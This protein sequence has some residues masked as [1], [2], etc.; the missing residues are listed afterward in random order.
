MTT[1]QALLGQLYWRE[2]LWLLLVLFPLAL[3]LWKRFMQQTSLRQYADSALHPW[4]KANRAAKQ[5]YWLMVSPFVIWLLLGISA[6]GPRLLTVTPDEVQPAQATAIIIVDQSR[7]MQ[8]SDVHPSRL[9]LAHNTLSQWA[10]DSYQTKTG[11]IIFAGTSHVVLPPTSDVLA[12][13]R[14]TRVIRE[15]QLPVHGSA[16]T[17]AMKQA[18][19]MLANQDGERAIILLTD[20]DYEQREWNKLNNIVSELGTHH[21]DLHMLGVGTPSPI[22]IHDHA[23]RWLTHNGAAVATR[24]NEVELKSLAT[25]I[26]VTYD[27]LNPDVHHQLSTVWQPRTV[28]LSEEYEDHVLWHELFPWFL[29]PAVLLLIV[30]HIR[31]PYIASIRTARIATN[32]LA[33]VVLSS[34]FF[35]PQ[36]GFASLDDTLRL[37]HKA[38]SQKEYEKSASLYAKV[39]GYEARMG[40]GASCFRTRDLDCAI[41]AF[42]QAAWQA[43]TDKR[44][45]M[46]AYNL[47]N[48]FFQQ[49]NF[50]SAITLYRD[51]LSYQPDEQDYLN[52]LVFTEEVQQQ[53]EL[54]L[55]QEAQSLEKQLGPGWQSRRVEQGLEILPDMS[56]SL[57]D[58]VNDDRLSDHRVRLSDEQ[59]RQYMQRSVHYASLETKQGTQ[60]QRQHDWSRFGHA[61]PT[62]A[63]R[64]EFWQRLFEMEEDILVSPETP[65]ILPGVSPW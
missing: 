42:S 29:I 24:L 20:G 46:A 3:L 25:G 37:A 47:G 34:L 21:I 14:A 17:A 35:Q 30:Q 56:V 57:D 18:V 23:G 2:P 16:V 60:Y 52:N 64:V 7:S 49:G 38:W 39:E 55:W 27:R 1:L 61:D 65:K 59:I 45:A 48:S 5:N 51:A 13:S 63:H 44:R 53:I 31:I 8:V 62:A 9:G 36:S 41:T 28:R 33:A 12:I 26:N 58:G 19:S 43:D 40:E 10:E 32:M 22:T 11:L 50:P 15:L 54:R 4:V 6:S